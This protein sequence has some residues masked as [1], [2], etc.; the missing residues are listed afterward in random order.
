MAEP[1]YTIGVDFGTE[2]ARAVLVDVADGL[3]RR[4]WRRLEM[5]VKLLEPMLL[6]I[7]ASIVLVVVVAL[8]LPVLKMSA[9]ID[10]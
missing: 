5:V 3:E 8:L 4:T 10:K 2:S 6:L 7:L 1:R 9:T